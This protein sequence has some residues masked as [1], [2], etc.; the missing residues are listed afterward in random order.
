[1]PDSGVQLSL[2]QPSDLLAMS[3]RAGAPTLSTRIDSPEAFALLLRSFDGASRL[4]FD[5]ETTGI[6]MTRCDLIGL[7]FCTQ[8]GIGSYVPVGD[9]GGEI[10]ALHPGSPEWTQLQQALLRTPAQLAAHNAKYDLGVLKRHGLPI[11]R[12]VYDTMIAQYAVAPLRRTGFGLKALAF[13]HLGWGMIEIA[14]LIGHGNRQLS[15][16]DVP[17]DVVVPYACAITSS[18]LPLSQT[19]RDA[20]PD[21]GAADR[22]AMSACSFRSLWHWLAAQSIQ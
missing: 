17:L 9:Y 11:Q 12:M 18:P 15:M 6:D 20:P 21:T 10:W 1:M 8:P 7:S 22:P 13:D 3:G 2:F 16:R 4:A 14:D 19:A 5:T